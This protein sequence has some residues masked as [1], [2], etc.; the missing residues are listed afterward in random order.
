MAVPNAQ[1]EATTIILADSRFFGSSQSSHERV[2]GF[3]RS[4]Q[5]INLLSFGPE[6]EA[7]KLQALNIFVGPNGS[8][9]R[10]SLKS[11]VF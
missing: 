5:P 11:L 8:G 9:S 3:L 7:I 2:G 1:V 6:T 10:I 4:V